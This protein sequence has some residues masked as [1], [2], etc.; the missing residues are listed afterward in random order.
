VIR[1]EGLVHVY[2][3]GTRALEGIDLAIGSGERIA[4]TGPNG[5]GKTTL[6]RHW[7]G[8]LRPTE[9][10]VTVDGR[11]TTGRHVAEL[12]RSVGIAFQD[13]GAQLFASTC[14]AEVAFGPRNLGLRGS[15][16]DRAVGDALAIVG[17]GEAGATNPYDL[18]PSRRRLLGIASMVAM[19]SPVLVL[20][21][22]TAGLDDD[23]VAL[24]RSLIDCLANAGR[25]VVAISHDPR[26]LAS[27]TFRREIRMDA[28]RLVADDAA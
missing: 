5:A 21:E 25:T 15:E 14:R 18:G 17:L 11:P 10:V 23:Q 1:C 3:D 20:D 4:L 13:P 8:L 28:G 2:A 22:P 7:N 6:V 19:G 9:G 16:L 27:G 24:V 26:L 12:A